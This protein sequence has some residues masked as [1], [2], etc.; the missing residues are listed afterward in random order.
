[1]RSMRTM[2]ILFL[3]SLPL[4]T[5]QAQDTFVEE[6]QEIRRYTVELI[7]FKYAQEVAAG[8]EI[9]PPD[10]PLP[11]LLPSE[12]LGAE[13]PFE[14]LRAEEQVPLDTEAPAA[15]GDSTL[16]HEVGFVLLEEEDFALV[17]IMDRL[18]RLDVYEPLMHFGWTQAPLPEEVTEPI[19]LASLA[20]PPDGLEGRLTLYLSR[21]LHLVVDLQL[22]AEDAGSGLDD[23]ASNYGDYRTTNE[24]TIN[25]FGDVVTPGPVRYR[26]QENRILRNGELRYFDH[27]KFGVLAK[28]LRIDEDAEQAPELEDTELLGYPVE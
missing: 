28:V 25:E 16:P 24:L 19:E 18:E 10:N 13:G 11:E 21:Y 2:T 26:I 12:D 14:D 27:P 23:E 7:I 6:E 8:S 3:V 22:D 4:V 20:V 17:E 5:L 15:K 9:F 1:M